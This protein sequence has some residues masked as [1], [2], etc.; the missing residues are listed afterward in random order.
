MKGKMPF[1]RFG[2]VRVPLTKQSKL[3][4]WSRGGDINIAA[5]YG[6]IRAINPGHP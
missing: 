5:T 3:D 6:K 4:S 2:S 1:G